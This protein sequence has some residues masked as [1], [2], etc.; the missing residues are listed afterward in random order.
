VLSIVKRGTSLGLLA[1]GDVEEVYTRTRSELLALIEIA[2]GGWCAEV[3]AF[4]EP[5]TG[6]TSDLAVATRLAAEFVG[7]HGMGRSVVSLAAVEE[8]GLSGTDLTGRVLADR[9]GRD[10]VDELMAAARTRVEQ[11]LRR[12]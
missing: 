11:R 4:G 5:S 3:L 12:H 6:A 7:A 10:E 8:S 1:H 9:R 2:L